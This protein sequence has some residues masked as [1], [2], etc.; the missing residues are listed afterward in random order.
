MGGG[1]GAVAQSKEHATP[2]ESVVG[3]IA[4]VHPLPTGWVGVRIM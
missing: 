3:S 1:G 4:V 2:D